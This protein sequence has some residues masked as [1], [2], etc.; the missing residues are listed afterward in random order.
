MSSHPAATIPGP[1]PS[2]AVSLGKFL[3][4]APL[5]ER[6]VDRLRSA[7][8]AIRFVAV[9]A[10]EILSEVS[11]AQAL[12]AGYEDFD[13]DAVLRAA[14]GLRWIHSFGAGVDRWIGPGLRE[15]P[16]VLTN[17][18]GV[19]GPNIAEHV[20]ALVLSFAR[21]LPAFARSAAGHRWER[22]QQTH[23]DPIVELPGQ[24][25]AIVGLGAI[26]EALAVRAKAFGLRV[27]GVRRTTFGELPPGVDAVFPTERA[28]EA[29]AQAHHVVNILPLTE[30]TRGFF[31]RA[32]LETFRPGAYFYNV[33]RG[34]TVDQDALVDLL[35]R[36][37]IAGAGLDVTSPEP[38]PPEHVLWTL[39][40]AILTNHTAGYTPAYQE[41][42]A[43]I[44]LDN[45]DRDARGQPLR[46]VVDKALGY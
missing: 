8:P 36:S 4:A 42:T 2:T 32:L 41:R 10:S 14:P 44:L 38:L 45:L 25:L 12:L 28:G 27:I 43:A 34:D 6:W 37:R 15:S 7:F 9:R 13:L 40:N 31:S 33:G 5:E 39:P 29:L 3:I 26:G 17:N 11:D 35:R 1:A 19:H 18:S 24:T 20:L 22:G 30:R 46:N 21:N 16:V 23:L